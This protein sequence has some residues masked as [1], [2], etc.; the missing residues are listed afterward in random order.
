LDRFEFV[1]TPKHGSWLDMAEI[2]L[3][4]LNN[5]CL[6]RRMES[7]EKVRDEAEAWEKARNGF[8]K[9]I[10]WQF[11]SEKARIK[12]KRLYPSYDR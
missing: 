8:D 6:G 4:V 3:N 12:L 1:F 7:I 5:Q 9:K 2:E 10:N 11:T